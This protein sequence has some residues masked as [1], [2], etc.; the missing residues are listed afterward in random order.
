ME[1]R[2]TQ[3]TLVNLS[4][5]EPD[6]VTYRNVGK[7]YVL[8]PK[9]DIISSHEAAYAEG[10]A[11]LKK[12]KADKEVVDKSVDSCISELREH[13]EANQSLAHAVMQSQG[14]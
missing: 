4:Q 6:T 10:L 3:L 1:N 11:T 2:R 13:L 8:A 12:L 9:S 14:A 7:A 5:L